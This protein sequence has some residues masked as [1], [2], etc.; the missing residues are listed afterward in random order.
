MSENNRT[1]PGGQ[2]RGVPEEDAVRKLLEEAGPRP[3]LAQDDLASIREAARRQW[4]RRYGGRAAPRSSVRWWVSLAAAALLAAAG[5]LWRARISDRPPPAAP[6]AAS[7]EIATGFAR[8][9]SSGEPPVSLRPGAVGRPLPEG[10]ELETGEG[11]EEWGRLALRMAGGAS[12]RLDAGTRVRLVST[13]LVELSR[14]AVYVDTGGEPGTGKEVAVRAPAGLF[15]GVGTQFEVRAVGEGAVTRL[16]VREGSVRLEL[17]DESVLTDTGQELIVSGD[18][19]L[20]RR[21][22][23]AYGPEWDWVLKTA[24]MLS[25]EGVK[26][27]TFLD[28]TAR[29]TGWRVVLA[30]EETRSLCDSVVLH[31]SIDHLTPAE[32]P[33]VVLASAGLGHRISDGTLVVFVAE[34]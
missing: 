5:L 16:R 25:I 8:W 30:D 18:G 7:L 29:E 1:R 22:M 24:P 20:A 31:G 6:A 2:W 4:R 17:R 14:G 21:P 13:A 26:V 12:V 27:R 3:V 33:G 10:S 15:Q 32:A 28:W 19:S 9:K 23:P 11:P 34:K